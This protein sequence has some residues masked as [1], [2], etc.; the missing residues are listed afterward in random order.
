MVFHCEHCLY[1]LQIMQNVNI[2]L[3][4]FQ[5]TSFFYASEIFLAITFL[6]I[7]LLLP[8]SMHERENVKQSVTKMNK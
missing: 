4:S 8:K 2:D 3:R 7:F 6:Q 5:L 1:I